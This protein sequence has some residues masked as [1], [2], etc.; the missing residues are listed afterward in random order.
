MVHEAHSNT[1]NMKIRKVLLRIAEMRACM[2][3]Y[4]NGSKILWPAVIVLTLA[5]FY[6]KK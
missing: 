4:L 5:A 3:N 2:G 1:K 6:C